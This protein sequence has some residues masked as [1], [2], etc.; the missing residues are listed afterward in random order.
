VYDLI[1][2]APVTFGPCTT[3][4]FK[5]QALNLKFVKFQISFQ[6][7]EYSKFMQIVCVIKLKLER[8]LARHV[9]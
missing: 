7:V 1:T 6:N 2:L 3:V 5:V 4:K 9:Q 8:G